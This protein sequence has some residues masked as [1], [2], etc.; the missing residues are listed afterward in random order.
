MMNIVD[1]QKEF[2]RHYYDMKDALF[3]VRLSM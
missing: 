1:T 2:H 3:M